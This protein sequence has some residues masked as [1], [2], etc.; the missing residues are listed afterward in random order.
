MYPSKEEVKS[1][2]FSGS[3]TS[4]TDGSRGRDCMFWVLLESFIIKFLKIEIY[5]TKSLVNHE[6]K[7]T[8]NLFMKSAWTPV[9]FSLLN[10]IVFFIVICSSESAWFHWI[11]TKNFYFYIMNLTSL[12]HY[13]NTMDN[14]DETRSWNHFKLP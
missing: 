11:F 10:N 2:Y 8:M 7:I 4:A 14:H 5:M 6:A 12:N 13:K 1:I 9:T 3:K